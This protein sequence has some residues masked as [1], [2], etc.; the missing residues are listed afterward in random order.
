MNLFLPQALSRGAFAERAAELSATDDAILSRF[1][2]HG[3]WGLATAIDL[4]GCDP[5]AIR[6]P[7]H[8]ERF[9]IALCDAIAMRRFGD[10]IIVRFGDDPRVSGY[11][12]AQLIE[13]S[14]I[15]GH[16]AEESDAAYIDIFSCKA[17]RPY[18]TAQLCSIWFGAAS[19]RVTVTLR[20]AEGEAAVGHGRFRATG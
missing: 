6:D 5:Q 19:A 18:L 7:H 12:L 2:E 11:S 10:P 1:R 16:F 15:A 14:L 20:Q 8:I 9:V 17:Y 13:T 4:G 3:P